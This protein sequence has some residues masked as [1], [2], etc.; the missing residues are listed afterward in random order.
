MNHEFLDFVEDILDAMNKAEILLEGVSYSQF[1]TDFR[2]NFA[3]V[4][5]LEILGEAAKRLPE[6]LR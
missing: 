4:R 3:V 5:I 1:E 6:D 2:I